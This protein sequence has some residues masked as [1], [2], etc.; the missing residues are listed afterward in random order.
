MIEQGNAKTQS[1]KAV[2][3]KGGK[4]G[5]SSNELPHLYN[6]VVIW[7]PIQIFEIRKALG[8]GLARDPALLLR[9]TKPLARQ[10]VSIPPKFAPS[11]PA[12]S[13]APRSTASIVYRKWVRI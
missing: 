8:R 13:P 9:K 5:L 3:A 4:L 2:Q 10:K 6:R 1:T 12:N 11:Q 7:K